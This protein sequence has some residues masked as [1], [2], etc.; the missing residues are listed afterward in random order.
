VGAISEATEKIGFGDGAR[1]RASWTDSPA[2]F[3]HSERSERREFAGA[4]PKPIFFVQSAAR[5]T[6]PA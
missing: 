6:D 3:D 2:L 5:P 4:S 1:Q